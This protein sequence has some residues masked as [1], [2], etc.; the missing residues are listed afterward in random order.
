MVGTQTEVALELCATGAKVGRLY[1][2]IRE[3]GCF[4]LSR[5]GPRQRKATL[6]EAYGTKA[7]ASTT[8]LISPSVRL[9]AD[10]NL[11]YWNRVELYKEVWNQPMVKLSRKYGHL[12]CQAGESVPATQ[13]TPPR[14]R[15]LGEEG[16]R[17]T[18]C[19]SPLSEFPHGSLVR[20]LI[21]A[22][23][24]SIQLGTIEAKKELSG[25]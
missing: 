22:K 11:T 19:T 23:R 2:Q 4:F 16:G 14:T 18:C 24:C 3:L 17:S 21:K 1:R 7:R 8:D 5:K 9:S 20:R 15:I 6:D 10:L 12:R 25:P 13:N